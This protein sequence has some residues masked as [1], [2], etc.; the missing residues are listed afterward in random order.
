MQRY[1]NYTGIGHGKLPLADLW[2]NSYLWLSHID[3]QFTVYYLQFT[4]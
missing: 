2:I 4:I 1:N 3:L